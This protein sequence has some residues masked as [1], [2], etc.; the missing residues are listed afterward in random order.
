MIKNGVHKISDWGL[1]KVKL[2]ESIT[3][4]GA[5]PQYAAPEQISQEFGKADER[6][7]VYQLGTVFY[8]L[9]TG[10]PPFKGETS[11]IYGSILKTQPVK[12]SEINPES[13]K[14]EKIIL[15][16]LNKNK[17]NR[18]SSMDELIKDLEQYYEPVIQ[19]NTMI[20]N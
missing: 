7:D 12:P 5:T 11:Q 14:I 2:G 8:E 18:Y 15:K 1:S 10:N 13:L 9:V 3:L 6:T 17:E 20:K 4:S 19:D 16:C